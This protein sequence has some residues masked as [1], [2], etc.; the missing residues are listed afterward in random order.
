MQTALKSSFHSAHWES[1]HKNIS[2]TARDT[3]ISLYELRIVHMNKIVEYRGS[4]NSCVQLMQLPSH[5]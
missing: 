4:N 2:E 5:G 1:H 3:H